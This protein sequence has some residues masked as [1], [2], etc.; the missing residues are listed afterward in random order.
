[1]SPAILHEPK[2]AAGFS[3]DEFAAEILRGQIAFQQLLA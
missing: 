2:A 1:M 3:R